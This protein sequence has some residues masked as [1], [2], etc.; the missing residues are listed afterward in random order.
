MRNRTLS[1]KREALAELSSTE[2][3]S[4]AGGYALTHLS[5]NLTDACG[6]GISFDHCPSIPINDCT[7]VIAIK[8]MNCPTR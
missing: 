8:T 6:H 2:L 4:V 5:C 3:V 1:L 7:A